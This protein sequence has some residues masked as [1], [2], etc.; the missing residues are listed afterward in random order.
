MV[1][2]GDWG[3][4]SPASASDP[5]LPW[6]PDVDALAETGL[7]QWAKVAVGREIPRRCIRAALTPRGAAGCVEAPSLCLFLSSY[8]TVL[9]PHTSDVTVF[10]DKVFKEVI[11]LK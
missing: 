10:R 5:A 3:R 6:C 1:W 2:H 11:D 8:V 4:P 7:L 9:I